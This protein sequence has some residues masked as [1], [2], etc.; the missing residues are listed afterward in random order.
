MNFVSTENGF[1]LERNGT[2]FTFS[3]KK[4]PTCCEDFVKLT[5]RGTIP[6][7]KIISGDRI[8]LPVDEGI[9]LAAEGEYELSLIH[10]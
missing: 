2:S 4:I 7:P 8:L 6:V 3:A 10:I 9:A 1:R 5:V